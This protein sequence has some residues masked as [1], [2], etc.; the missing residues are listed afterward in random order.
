MLQ[1]KYL[2][3]RGDNCIAEFTDYGELV[4]YAEAMR[5]V[6][7]S[8][9]YVFYESIIHDLHNGLQVDCSKIEV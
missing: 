9:T 1:I 4:V 8:R 5:R 2:V 7:P 3:Y 6:C